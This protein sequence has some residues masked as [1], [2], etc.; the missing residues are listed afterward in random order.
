[1]NGT[2]WRY[3]SLF[4]VVDMGMHIETHELPIEGQSIRSLLCDGTFISGLV[5]SVVSVVSRSAPLPFSLLRM[6][7]I[8][9]LIAGVIFFTVDERVS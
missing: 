2:Q 3:W 8:H 1:M 9:F 5:S 4:D 7:A 6:E